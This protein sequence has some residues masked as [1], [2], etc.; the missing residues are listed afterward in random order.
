MRRYGADVVASRRGVVTHLTAIGLWHVRISRVMA[1][2]LFLVNPT[3]AY[4]PYPDWA[5][6]NHA[7]A[8]GQRV[9]TTWNTGTRCRGMSAGDRALI[10][11]VG[12]EPRGLV[13][14]GYVDG[15]IV[16][17]PHWNP[18]ARSPET[19]FVDLEL[20][21]LWP[22]DDPLPLEILQWRA[23]H[24]LWTPRQSGTSIDIDIN[25]LLAESS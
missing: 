3:R 17:G 24:V 15:P 11:K 5:R 8:Q 16:I 9:R 1:T 2:F 13:G 10:V 7:L 25:Q 19:G 4:D 18:D 14:I 6:W 12:V 21:R 22:I 23:P 20:A